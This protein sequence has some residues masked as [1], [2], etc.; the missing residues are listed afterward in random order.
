MS[1]GLRAMLNMVAEMAFRCAMIN[2]Y[3]G[4]EAIRKTPGIVLIDE[5][6][7]HLH[8][9]WQRRVVQDLKKA[10]PEIQFIVTTHSPYIIQSLQ[11]NELIMLDEEIQLSIDPFR[12]GIEDISESPMGV[13]DVPRSALFIEREQLATEYFS[14]IRK[15][16]NSEDSEQVAALRERLNA[17]EDRFSDN[18]VFISL[19]KAERTGKGL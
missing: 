7:M 8:P 6:D 19:M 15:G 2:G 9:N 14:L 12:M 13:D 18:P 3:L 10:F 17:L 1:D 16:H 5:L 4:K 11:R